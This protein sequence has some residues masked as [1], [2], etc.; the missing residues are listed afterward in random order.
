[1]SFAIDDL[2]ASD[3]ARTEAAARRRP[4]VFLAKRIAGNHS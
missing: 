1:M 3:E 4:D 2:R